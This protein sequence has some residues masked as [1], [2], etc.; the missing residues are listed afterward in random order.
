MNNPVFLAAL[1]RATDREIAEEIER[2]E[3]AAI[4]TERHAYRRWQGGAA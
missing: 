3:I 1:G 2:L 4:E